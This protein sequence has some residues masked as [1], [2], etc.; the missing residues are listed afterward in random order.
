MTDEAVQ[1]IDSVLRECNEA[2]GASGIRIRAERRGGMIVL[3]GT[4]PSKEDGKPP[5][6]A[7]V[8]TGI[9]ATL[10]AWHV[11]EK[12]TGLMESTQR[13]VSS[14]GFDWGKK[15]VAGRSPATV[16]GGIIE[17]FERYCL[18]SQTRSNYD[19]AYKP[20]I[21]RLKAM[22]SSD[23]LKEDYLMK[24]AS[25]VNSYDEN[26]RSRQIAR[27]CLELMGKMF[28][29]ESFT[30]KELCPCGYK[31]P[32][33]KYDEQRL[34]IAL[35]EDD[36][37]QAFQSIP[38]KEWRFAF[39]LMAAY[40]LRNHEVFM[41]D[42]SELLL[43]EV[44]APCVRVRAGTKTGARSVFPFP[45]EWLERMDMRDPSNRL[46]DVNAEDLTPQRVGQSVARQF[47]R[48]SVPFKPYDLRH[49]YVVRMV[50][51]FDIPLPVAAKIAGH[52]VSVMTSTY[53]RVLSEGGIG[54]ACQRAYSRD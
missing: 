13:E 2:A 34:N 40:G 24:L 51:E 43:P 35:G 18:E 26:S 23:E 31:G 36:V 46:P 8:S 10:P 30:L 5:K 45:P 32:S 20:Y 19:S 3:R 38:S 11:R 7:R 54:R 28:I 1:D 16:Q 9:K 48:Y 42:F 37:L 6:Q 22:F 12:L 39:A 33:N 27:H 44:A 15:K 25:V 41:C 52:S 4:F 29:Q 49:N 47:A 17:K 21:Q 14:G 50:T 53:H